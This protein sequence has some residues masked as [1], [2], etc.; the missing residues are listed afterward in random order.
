MEISAAEYATERGSWVKE[1]WE[2]R[3]LEP[4]KRLGGHNRR[5]LRAKL[6]LL[7]GPFPLFASPRDPFPRLPAARLEATL[8][9][10][11]AV[12][13]RSHCRPS[14]GRRH[15]TSGWAVRGASVHAAAP[16]KISVTPTSQSC[17]TSTSCSLRIA[18]SRSMIGAPHSGR[19]SSVRPL[20]RGSKAIANP[21]GRIANRVL[22]HVRIARG[23][24]RLPVTEERSDQ[25]QREPRTRR[26]ASVRVTEIVQP[27]L[28]EFRAFANSVPR[29][30]QVH[31]RLR[32][33]AARDDP[34]RSSSDT[35]QHRYR[36]SPV[37][38]RPSAPSFQ[39]L[40]DRVEA[41]G[42][43]RLHGERSRG[44]RSA[45]GA[46][47]VHAARRAPSRSRCGRELRALP[48]AATGR[49]AANR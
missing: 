19:L 6:R 15:P 46:R 16:M 8:D 7:S 11:G 39:L 28:A 36:R 48:E 40:T 45:L 1:S 30:G 43:H 3:H 35:I 2:S 44:P 32:R 42:L 4:T 49:E 41:N 23:R 13:G 9:V 24:S 25:V 29:L 12:S 5:K 18:G 47:N 27:H 10:C 21:F 22:S 33:I 17:R 37:R 26:A 38:F 34:G 14:R 31:E 20:H